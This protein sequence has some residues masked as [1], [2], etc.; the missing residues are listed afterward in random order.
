ML[1]FTPPVCP[2]CGADIRGTVD[3]IPAIAELNRFE[4]GSYEWSGHTEVLWD[5]QSGEYDDQGRAEVCCANGHHWCAEMEEQFAEEPN[6]TARE[7]LERQKPCDS[8]SPS[9][10]T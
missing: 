9:S 1:K 5:G 4:D 7:I 8:S 6:D 10:A 2:T 3:T